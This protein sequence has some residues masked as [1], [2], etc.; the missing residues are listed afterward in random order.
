MFYIHFIDFSYKILLF[1]LLKINKL[2]LFFD[3]YKLLLNI[4]S[5]YSIMYSHEYLL[6]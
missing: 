2:K 3:I 6:I 5:I 1:I 4:I